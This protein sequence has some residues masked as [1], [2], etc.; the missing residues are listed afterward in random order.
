MSASNQESFSF[1]TLNGDLN[2]VLLPKNDSNKSYTDSQSANNEWK[3]VTNRR[4]VQRRYLCLIDKL[5][6]STFNRIAANHGYYDWISVG[7]RQAEN[8]LQPLY[9]VIAE[10]KHSWNRRLYNLRTEIKSRLHVPYL[11]NKIDLHKL[12]RIRAPNVIAETFIYPHDHDQITPNSFC[13]SVWVWRPEG[14]YGGQGVHFIDCYENYKEIINNY[15]RRTELTPTNT[16]EKNE[17]KLMD[18]SN[19]EIMNGND[20][21]VENNYR[22]YQNS[23]VHTPQRERAV[24]SRYVEPLLMNGYKFHLRLFFLLICKSNGI[25]TYLY[26]SGL[27]ASALKPFEMSNFENNDIHDTRLCHQD[28]RFPRDFPTENNDI[29]VNNIDANNDIDSNNIDENNDIDANKVFN[30]AIDILTTVSREID[31]WVTLYP[32]CNNAFEIFGC[33]LMVDRNGKVYLIEINFKPDFSRR[34]N[35]ET[36]WLSDFI[37]EGIFEAALD[38]LFQRCNQEESINHKYVTHLYK[39]PI[40]REGPMTPPD[41]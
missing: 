14:G 16:R 15:R 36:K 28:L 40:T 29:D 12:L 23:K 9:F 31:G 32:E 39:T 3:V 38:P 8:Q 21:Y 11:T 17:S 13:N 20:Y 24:I 10:G 18:I 30:G 41:T 1:N 22:R 19:F 35:R 2:S 25:S 4:K 27:I 5:D 33:D 34:T 6:I 37:F 7:I 26:K